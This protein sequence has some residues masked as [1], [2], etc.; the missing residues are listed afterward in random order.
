MHGIDRVHFLSSQSGLSEAIR[1]SGKGE[2][3]WDEIYALLV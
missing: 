3:T 1:A 2:Q